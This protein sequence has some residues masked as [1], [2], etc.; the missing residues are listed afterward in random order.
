MSLACF[1]VQY[2]VKLSIIIFW[3]DD[4]LLDFWLDSL[5]RLR[6]N[7]LNICILVRLDNTHCRLWVMKQRGKI[8]AVA[9]SKDF[10]ND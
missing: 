10:R 5:D 2:C 1:F 8:H 9:V 6:L 7:S 4:I 3:L